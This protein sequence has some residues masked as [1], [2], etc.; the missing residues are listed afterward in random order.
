MQEGV[1]LVIMIPTP[2]AT[3]EEGS[4]QVSPETHRGSR[5]GAA[6]ESRRRRRT[7]GPGGAGEGQQVSPE[8]HRGSW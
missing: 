6:G 2:V 1:R 8:T 4:R 3:A 5:G 7:G